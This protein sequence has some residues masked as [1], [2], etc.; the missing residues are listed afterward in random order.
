MSGDAYRALPGRRFPSG[1]ASFGNGG[2][3]VRRKRAR[4][5]EV[6]G[7][8]LHGE[9]LTWQIAEPQ[10]VSHQHSR[11]AVNNRGQA[12]AKKEQKKG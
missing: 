9:W 4:Y 3:H 2:S 12:R 1:K 11:K 5:L 7:H 8:V 6:Q 10:H